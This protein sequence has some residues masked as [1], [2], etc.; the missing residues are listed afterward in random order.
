MLLLLLVII[1]AIWL[2]SY[3]GPRYYPA[4][5]TRYSQYPLWGG[6]SHVLLIILALLVVLWL[7]GYIRIGGLNSPVNRRHTSPI[8]NVR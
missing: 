4:Y 3:A 8:I 1:A 7:L 2:F 6:R 5:T